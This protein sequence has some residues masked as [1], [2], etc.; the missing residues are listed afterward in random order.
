M[1]L[2]SKFTIVCLG[3]SITC[4]WNGPQ[5]PTFWQELVDKK[6]GHGQVKI[7][8]AGVNGETAQD[9]YYRLNSDVLPHKPDLVTIMFGHNDVYMHV[10]PTAYER[11]LDN[12]VNVLQQSK[13]KSI[14]LLS[15]NKISDPKIE[16]SYQPYLIKLP[17]LAQEK[18]I[19]FIDVW[20]H[21]FTNQDVA[22]IYTYKFDYAGLSGTDYIHP[23]SL[24]HHLIAQYLF[25]QPINS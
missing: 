5:Y 8:S 6:Y 11:Y 12:T 3:D 17:Q 1:N 19:T 2:K 7:I 21:A 23:N 24:G 14:W 18:N 20:S 13:L 22:K 25:Q 15:P 10:D 9:G 16:P 4:E